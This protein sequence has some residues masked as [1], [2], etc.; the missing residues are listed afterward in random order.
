MGHMPLLDFQLF[1]FSRSL[2]S[3]TNSDIGLYVVSYP[4]RIYR[5]LALWLFIAWIHNNFVSPLNYF[6]SFVPLLAPNPGSA[7]AALGANKPCYAA[8]SITVTWAAVQES[9]LG[10]F[11]NNTIQYNTNTPFR[12]HYDYAD[13]N[14]LITVRFHKKLLCEVF[15]EK[16]HN[17][18]PNKPASI[19]ASL[20]SV[21]MPLSKPCHPW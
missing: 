7:T 11:A 21:V 20:G 19:A 17:F 3:C 6:L 9:H 16:C 1:N 12:I 5:P 15:S 14:L 8:D 18:G 2:Q 10:P 4:E 13:T